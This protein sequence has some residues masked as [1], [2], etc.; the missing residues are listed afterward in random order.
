[1]IRDNLAGRK[2]FVYL[3]SRGDISAFSIFTA[4]A[5]KARCSENLYVLNC[6][7]SDPAMTNTIDPIN[8]L[9]GDE[10][11]FKLL[12]GE[13]FGPVLSALCKV[14]HANSQLID[15]SALHNFL[16][17]SSLIACKDE[18]GVVRKYLNAL[19]RDQDSIDAS[20]QKK[21]QKAKSLIAI[22]ES[23]PMFSFDPEIDIAS[24]YAQSKFLCI[25]LPAIE[26]DPD[27]LVPLQDLFTCLV[28]NAIP[29][30]EESFGLPSFIID[31]GFVP[32]DVA[33][34]VLERFK[35]TNTVFAYDLGWRDSF[36]SCRGN[37]SIQSQRLIMNTVKTAVL[38]KQECVLSDALKVK[39]FDEGISGRDVNHRD[40]CNQS[41]GQ[42]HVW[43][44]FV[45]KRRKFWSQKTVHSQAREIMRI[46][47]E[48][49]N[50]PTRDIEYTITRKRI[51]NQA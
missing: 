8:P 11:A 21:T 45:I 5:R 27:L 10:A 18:I 13:E 51:A 9:V 1:M 48:L 37:T 25:N 22:L 39:L 7:T 49:F 19:D 34:P 43:G 47:T 32:L 35:K 15:F 33:T 28:S 44:N 50:P 20:H 2:P 29:T 23:L 6:V 46:D 24:I 36:S 12:F 41:P 14:R 3:N 38:M 4:G 42:A 16:S 17:I 30:T 40:L 31:S 26:K